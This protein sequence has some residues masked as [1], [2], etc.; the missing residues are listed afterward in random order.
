MK[1]NICLLFITFFTITLSS[2][3]YA[4]NIT[5]I[6]ATRAFQTLL[7]T[8]PTFKKA[9]KYSLK[10]LQAITDNKQTIAYAIHLKPCG[11]IILSADNRLYPLLAYSDTANL[12]LI[13]TPKNSMLA[14]LKHTQN[15]R[16]KCLDKIAK[17]RSPLSHK[18]QSFQKQWT[19]LLTDKPLPS[20]KTRSISQIGPLLNSYWGQQRDAFYSNDNTAENT[21]NYYTPDHNPS[22]CVATAMGQ[23]MRYYAWPKKGRRTHS[24]TSQINSHSLTSNFSAHTYDWNNILND[25]TYPF[26]G[27]KT[28]TLIQRQNIGQLLYDCGVSVDMDY[29]HSASSS[30]L[31]DVPSALNNY[32][33]YSSTAQFEPIN[34]ANKIL[35]FDKINNN[36]QQSCPVIIGIPGHAVVADGIKQTNSDPIL[37]HLNFGWQGSN[38]GWYDITATFTSDKN[39]YPPGANRGTRQQWGG[40][41]EAVVN[42]TPIP[43]LQIPNSAST[44]YTISWQIADNYN[45]QTYELQETTRSTAT[46]FSDDASADNGYWTPSN[47]SVIVRGNYANHLCWYT[48][49]DGVYS[50]LIPRIIE[51]NNIFFVKNNSTISF[52]YTYNYF[53]AQ[54]AQLQIKRNRDNYWQTIVTYDGDIGDPTWTHFSINLNNISGIDYSGQYVTFRFLFTCKSEESYWHGNIAN[55]KN[56]VGFCFDNFT[57]SNINYYPLFQTINNNITTTNYSFTNK[58]TGHYAYRV[59]SKKLDVWHDWSEV[60]FYGVGLSAIKCTITPAL[61]ASSAQ[62]KLTTGSDT[63]WYHSEEIARNIFVGNYTVAFKTIA[64]WNTPANQTASITATGQLISTNATY[65]RQAMLAPSNYTLTTTSSTEITLSWDYSLIGDEQGFSIEK[66]TSS[67]AA[68]QEIT[69]SVN[70]NQTSYTDPTCRPNTTYQYRVAVYKTGEKVYTNQLSATTASDAITD[71]DHDGLED[72]WEILYFKNLDQ[73]ATDDTDNDQFSNLAEYYGGTN[74]TIANNRTT[75]TYNLKYGWNLC[76]F[77]LIPPDPRFSSILKTATGIIY[78]GKIYSYDAQSQTYQ[79]QTTASDKKG[80]WIYCNGDYQLEVEGYPV[81]NNSLELFTGWNLVGVNKQSQTPVNN[82]IQQIFNWNNSIKIYDYINPPTPLNLGSGYWFRTNQ[83]ITITP[84][85]SP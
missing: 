44:N 45:A 63:N 43:N 16:L 85:N 26:Q 15:A 65:T 73:T 49:L 67:T 31:S 68:W 29:T 3:N 22:G 12:N 10:K 27:T 74:P 13:D 81:T 64:G 42:I 39:E 41:T 37:Y 76:S 20:F 33:N 24:Y 62:W 34:Y 54:I 53:D 4:R 80:Y 69:G 55:G 25:Y 28:S 1:K 6:E 75:V 83:N 38:N 84:T 35:L 46:T 56:I 32:F 8:F 23:I 30:S 61:A 66:R 50:G 36:L 82:A 21:Y 52:D 5:T 7:K 18:I 9:K 14:I 40:A 60:K 72:N 59:R 70:S 77:P 78:I 58:A 79:E 17:T 51:G 11:F 57:I 48:F 19:L 47:S 2:S 71:T